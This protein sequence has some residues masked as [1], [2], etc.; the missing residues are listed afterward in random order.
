MEFI[1]EVKQKRNCKT[2]IFPDIYDLSSIL[3]KEMDKAPI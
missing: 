2:G 1:L 3:I